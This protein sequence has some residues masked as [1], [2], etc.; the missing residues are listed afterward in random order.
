MK[1]IYKCKVNGIVGRMGK[2]LACC[3]K[4]KCG[5]ESLCGAHGNTK[6]VYK[7]KREVS[8]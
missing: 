4:I 8:K 5:S 1:I 3:P 2:A 7:V 6:C